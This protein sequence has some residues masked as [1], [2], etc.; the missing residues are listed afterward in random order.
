[1]KKRPNI[2]FLMSDQHR[3]DIT[4]Y[5]GNRVVRTP[6]LDQLAADGV[7]FRNAYTPS[8]ICVPARQCMMSGQLPKTC[9]CEGWIDLKPNYLT[10]AR[11]LSRHAYNTVCSGKL[12]HMGPDQMQG[13]TERLAADTAVSREHV[14]GLIASEAAKYKSLPGTG[15]WSNEKEVKMAGV[16]LGPYQRV[17]LQTLAATEFF[18]E[19]YFCDPTY[20]RPRLQA[21][22]LLKTS[23]LLPHF[24][25]LTD[26]DKFNYYLNRVPV[27]TDPPPDHPVLCLSQQG[28]RVRVSERE[29]QRATAAYYGMVETADYYCG[30]VLDKLRDVGQDLD[31]W[32]IIYTSDHGEML[33]QHGIWEKTRFYEASARVP[34]IIRWPAGFNG[35][36]VLR[37]NVNLCDLFATICDLSGIPVPGGLDSRS[38]APLLRGEPV[39]WQNESVSYVNHRTGEHVMIKQ[40]D[41]KYQYYG[42]DCP[43]V[44]FD[45]QKDPQENANLAREPEYAARMDH[46]RGR[47]SSLGYGP[48]P[49]ENYINAGYSPSP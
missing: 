13:W 42:E 12:H 27:Y 41:L 25:F 15:K 10:F 7:V 19:R 44:L 8:P 33:G 34:L 30:R 21:P 20:D 32:I 18:I 22:L 31:Q 5:E 47:L 26:E 38:L 40:D 1:M 23:I 45:L 28:E 11:E 24:P 37:E 35:E 2:L 39:N 16:G 48:T 4:G 36:R 9:D 49:V 14:E 3:A 46:F 43:E 17:D 6:Y 29:I